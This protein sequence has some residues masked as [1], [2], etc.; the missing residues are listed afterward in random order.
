MTAIHSEA[1][2]EQALVKVHTR[3]AR[4]IQSVAADLNVRYHTLK[5]WMKKTSSPKGDTK[6]AP[7]KRPQDWSAAEQLAALQ[8]T[9]GVVSTASSPII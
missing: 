4:T 7:E 8:E 2:I 9:H 1:F 6:P 5:Y 3:G